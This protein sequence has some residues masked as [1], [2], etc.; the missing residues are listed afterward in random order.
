MEQ[1]WSLKLN[2]WTK[3][4]LSVCFLYSLVNC[5]LYCNLNVFDAD[6]NIE[7]VSGF[8]LF[9]IDFKRLS[10]TQSSRITAC[11]CKSLY[12]CKSLIYS[13][14]WKPRIKENVS[15][16]KGKSDK[17]INGHILQDDG[18]NVNVYVVVRAY[19]EYVS[20]SF[21]SWYYSFMVYIYFKN[22]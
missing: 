6:L 8:I 9:L 18:I 1:I 16:K 19:I 5:N 2:P 4:C 14:K 3:E 13:C 10:V 7:Y 12:T 21:L 11:T 15:V 17:E 22:L 20:V